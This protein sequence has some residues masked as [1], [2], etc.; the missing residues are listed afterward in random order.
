MADLPDIKPPRNLERAGGFH[1]REKAGRI[2]R[3]L[4]VRKAGLPRDG[5]VLDVGCG[6][7][8]MAVPLTEHLTARGRYEGLD[9]DAEAIRWCA[10]HIGAAHPNFRFTAVNAQSARY[11]PTGD[12][13]AASLVFPYE[14]STFDVAFLASVFTHL[15]PDA[16]ARYFHELA[17]VLKPGGRCLA[18]YFLLNERSEREIAAGRV[19]DLHRFP[20]RLEGCRVLNLELPESAVAHEEGRIRRLYAE[21]GFRIVEPIRYGTWAGQP[22]PVGQDLILAER[23]RTA[24]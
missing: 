11:N 7:G 9:V 14:D 22:S 12:A 2:W 15:L 16:V 21:C 20:Q 13:S 23:A 19:K 4:I 5:A 18:S 17:R 10:T 6:L 8:R 3:R 24:A 1:Q